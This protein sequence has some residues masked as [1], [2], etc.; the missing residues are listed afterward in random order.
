MGLTSFV[1]RDGYPSDPEHIFL[2]AGASAGVSLLLSMLIQHPNSG[3]LIPIPQYRC[4]C[5]VQRCTDTLLPRRAAGLV[6]FGRGS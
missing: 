2:T 4:A 5:P 1:E 6:D 3:I